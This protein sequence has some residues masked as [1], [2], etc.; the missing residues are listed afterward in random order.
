MCKVPRFCFS[1]VQGVKPETS[2]TDKLLLGEGV[3]EE[4]PVLCPG[5]GLPNRVT[6]RQRSEEIGFSSENILWLGC[7]LAQEWCVLS[8]SRGC[9]GIIPSSV[10]VAG[11]SFSEDAPDSYLQM[12]FKILGYFLHYVS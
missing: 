5:E 8:L 7:N 4:I 12:T 1:V 11:S 6:L 9:A 3:R 2:K 10:H